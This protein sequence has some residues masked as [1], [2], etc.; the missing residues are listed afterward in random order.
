MITSGNG[1][2]GVHAAELASNGAHLP[3][4]RP[5]AD[6]D[7][8]GP[9]IGLITAIPEEFA[10]MRALL[11]H[12][13]EHYVERDPAPYVLGFLP[14]RE[15]TRSHRVVLTL[16]GATATN[17]AANGCTNLV[18]SFPTVVAVI[19]VGIAAGMPNP[20]RPQHHVRLGD[21]VVATQ[22]LVDY[23]HVRAV[24]DGVQPRR[25]FPLPSPRF[26]RCADML[27]AD[28][29]S[30][31]RPW[32][33]WLGEGRPAHLTGYGRPPQ[34][35][36]VLQD[37]G[38][39]KL[40][41]PPRNRSGHRKGVP[42]IHYGAIGSADRSLRDAT[43]RDQLATRHGFLAIEMEGAGIG[44]SSFLNQLEWFVIRG[45]SDYGDGHRSEVWRRHASLTAA[46]YLRALLAKCLPLEPQFGMDRTEAN[47]LR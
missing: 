13:I 18:R 4:P 36:D 9:T 10:A 40:D 35:T 15:V 12:P 37:P 27:K 7:Q 11:E 17:A 28:E 47:S 14:S 39:N 1:Y 3:K 16:L 2:D 21:V 42:K 19:M 8:A 29:L 5:P 46:C 45:I 26:A 24:A 22:G 25:Q 34:H 41:H 31:H 44:S 38:G 43:T 6:D 23:D 32:E 30:G 20:Y 33:H